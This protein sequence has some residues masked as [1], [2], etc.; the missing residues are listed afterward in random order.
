MGFCRVYYNMFS[1]PGQRFFIEIIRRMLYNEFKNIVLPGEGHSRLLFPRENVPAKERCHPVV[2]ERT[3]L[4]KLW[5]RDVCRAVKTYL[6]GLD[7]LLILL[8]VFCSAYGCVL[9]RSAVLNQ[10]GYSR[11]LPVQVAA[12]AAGFVLMLLLSAIDY[13]LYRYFWGLIGVVCIGLLLTTLLIGQGREA[14]DDAAWIRLGAISIQPSEFVKVGFFITFSCHCAA[15]HEK[16][17]SLPSVILLCVHGALPIGFV[18]LQRDLGS[19]AIFLF[20]FIAMMFMAGIRM[21]YFAAGGLTAAVAIPLAWFFLLNDFHRQ[22]FLVAFTPEVD[23]LGAGYQQYYGRMAI[24]SGQF[25]GLGLGQGIQTQSGF[26]SEAQNDYIFAVA[27]EEL[28]F[29]GATLILLLLTLLIVRILIIGI[30][31][32]NLQGRILCAGAAAMF[33][34]QLIVNISMCLCLAPVVGVTL[35][36]FSAGGS[37]MVTCWAAIGLVESVRIHSQPIR[38][39]SGGTVIPE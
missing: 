16:L 27:A 39:Q 18:I 29:L 30:R 3:R 22:R 23:P 20:L 11:T 15:M 9:I 33:A 8:A 38:L 32:K 1:P 36:F 37:S 14:A 10:S 21:R 13:G 6:A 24:G 25:R 7:K 5:W 35:P 34:S 19:A 26:V 28:G 31:A 12:I 17:S 4:L 2:N